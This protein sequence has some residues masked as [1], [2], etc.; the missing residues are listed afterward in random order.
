MHACACAC[1]RVRVCVCVCVCVCVRST[2]CFS[3]PEPEVGSLGELRR[4]SSRHSSVRAPLSNIN[5]SKATEPIA[6]KFYQKHHY[7]G[8]GCIR[9][10]G[11]VRSDQNSGFHSPFLHYLLAPSLHIIKIEST[12]TP[13]LPCQKK[14]IM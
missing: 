13:D 7:G 8:K 10:G 1:A 9:F 14:S 6:I 11:T 12:G 2:F 5:I 3:S 4:Y